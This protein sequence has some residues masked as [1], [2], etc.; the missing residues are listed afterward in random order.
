MAFEHNLRV[1]CPIRAGYGQSSKAERKSDA[2]DVV[3]NDC[4]AVLES[5]GIMRVPYAVQGSDFPFAADMIAHKPGVITELI[6]IGGRPCLPGGQ[7]IDG[8]GLWQKFFV[9]AAQKSPH[10]VDFASSAVMAMSKRIGPEAMLRKLC[11]DSPADLALLETDEF[12]Q[13][14]VANIELMAGKS[15]NSARAFAREYSA[16]QQDWSDRVPATA[17]IPVRV[18]LAEEDPTV[19]LAALPMLKAAYPWMQVDVLA[20]AGLA[21]VFQHPETLIPIMAEAARRAASGAPISRP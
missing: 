18:F 19:D 3:R 15:A 11:K 16:F 10:L 8:L 20:N 12:K 5:L 7:S 6:S 17:H 21:L 1:I 4:V 2:F 14:L 13:V 9:S